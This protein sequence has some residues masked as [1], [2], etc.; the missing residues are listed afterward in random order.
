MRF[1]IINGPNLNMLG[2]REK[3]LYGTKTLNEINDE[4]TA[5]CKGHNAEAEFFQSNIE[6]EI[7][8]AIHK[9]ASGYD[10]VVLNAGAY[11]HYSIAIADA[12]KSIDTPV[13]EVHIT[14]VQAREDYRK[15]SVIGESCKGVVAGFGG[16]SYILGIMALM[17]ECK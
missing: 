1:L 16:Y 15:S 6:G 3:N 14:N 9:A 11:T 12:I 13:V 8:N 4:I 17:N 10:G 2:V 7:I 5:F